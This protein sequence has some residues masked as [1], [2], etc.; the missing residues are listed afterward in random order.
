M[1]QLRQRMSFTLPRERSPVIPGFSPGGS[2][3][4][5][6]LHGFLKREEFAEET[7]G[8]AVVGMRELTAGPAWI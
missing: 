7:S 1:R 2:R 3:I 4:S 5:R 6:F 8:M